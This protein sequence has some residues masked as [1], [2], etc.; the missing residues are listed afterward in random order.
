MQE[1]PEIEFEYE[2]DIQVLSYSSKFHSPFRAISTLISVKRIT[3][4]S[5]VKLSVD[6]YVLITFHISE[7]TD[8]TTPA[9]II[10]VTDKLDKRCEYCA[11][12]IGL[13]D[14]DKEEIDAIRVLNNM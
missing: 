11:E 5:N 6:D 12:F 9:K 14:R 7:T 2:S 3:F 4:I 13:S 8:I 1:I 10:T